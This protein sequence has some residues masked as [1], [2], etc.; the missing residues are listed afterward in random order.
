MRYSR[1]L[2]NRVNFLIYQLHKLIDHKV[3]MKIT[4]LEYLLTTHGVCFYLGP[5][6]YKLA[7]AKYRYRLTVTTMFPKNFG[8]G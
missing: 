2:K 8:W 5:S 4:C 7:K 3:L 1:Y 6:F